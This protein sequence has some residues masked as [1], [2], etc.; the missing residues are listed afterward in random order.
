MPRLVRQGGLVRETVEHFALALTPESTDYV[1]GP[2]LQSGLATGLLSPAEVSL[3]QRSML[4]WRAVGDA[5]TTVTMT[6][7]AAVRP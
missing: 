6:L 3:W 4:Q 7:V 1:L 5:T 2:T